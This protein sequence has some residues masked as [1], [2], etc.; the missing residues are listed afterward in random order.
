MISRDLTSGRSVLALD[1]MPAELDADETTQLNNTNTAFEPKAPE[2]SVIF[3]APTSGKVL[4]I[5]GG[6]LQ[7]GSGGNRIHL[8]PETRKNDLNGTIVQP[9]SISRNSWTS[10]GAA[11][12]NYQYGCQV[13]LIENL[14]PGQPYFS[15]AMISV[16]GSAG[17]GADPDIFNAQIIA[18]PTA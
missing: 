1:G 6:G 14:E 2:V 7:P 10:I 16:S 18:I 13:D 15:R 5:V 12:T 17:S 8:A 4:T 11:M 3:E 9:P